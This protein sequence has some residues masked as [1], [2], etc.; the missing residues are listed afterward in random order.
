[1]WRRM[2][3]SGP[4]A[5]FPGPDYPLLILRLGDLAAFGRAVGGRRLGVSLSLAGVL[6][7]TGVTTTGTAALPLAGVD[8]VAD[9]LIAAG[10]L[11]GP[12]GDGAGQEQRRSR[13]SNENT[14]PVHRSSLWVLM[15]LG[16][17]D[18]RR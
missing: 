13:S 14:L 15:A 10:L 1:G 11:V 5:T 18:A 3:R 9:H 2:M 16:C 17:R 7:G 4:R 12:G 6:A 8:P